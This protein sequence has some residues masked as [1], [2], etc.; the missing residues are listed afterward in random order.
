MSKIAKCIE[1]DFRGSG[2]PETTGT[3]S[4]GPFKKTIDGSGTVTKNV[5]GLVLGLAATSE[6][7]NVCVYN[8]DILAYDIDEI[9][10]V[11]FLAKVDVASADME[12]TS[13]VLG[14]ASAR[15]DDPDAVANS[16][17]FKKAA[18]ADNAVFLESD[19]GTTNVDDYDSGADWQDGVWQRFQI[20]FATGVKTV[21]P[22]FVAPVGGK[23]NIEFRVSSGTTYGPNLQ[24]VGQNQAFSLEGVTGGL[25]LIAQ[26]QKTADTDEVTLS[27]RSIKVNLKDN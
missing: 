26:I 3:A 10:S 15:N 19:N 25:Q 1:Y 21:A 27:I 5:D 22:P 4:D 2:V 14:L 24:R 12:A 9:H 17:W 18:G 16:V 11:E 13:I 6:V 20:D 23:N 8:D 7:E